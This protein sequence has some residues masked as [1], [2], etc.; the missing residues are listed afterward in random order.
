LVEKIVQ[1][2]QYA[3]IIYIMIYSNDMGL[4]LPWKY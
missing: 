2:F 3:I 4:R 1:N